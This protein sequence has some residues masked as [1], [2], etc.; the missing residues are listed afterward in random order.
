M[1]Q[2]KADVLKLFTSGG[3]FHASNV[4]MNTLNFSNLVK[5]ILLLFALFSF[6]SE[7]TAAQSSADLAADRARAMNL[8][9][10]NRYI[11]AYPVLEK[12][13]ALLPND[14]DV[15]THYG[16]AAAARSSILRDAKERKAQ[17]K[18]AFDVLT[19]AKQLG[20]ANVMALHILDQLPANGGDEDNFGSENPE[21]E[22]AL[23][24]GE[25]HFGRGDYPKAHDSYAKAFKLNPK[26]YEAVLFLGDTFYAQKKYSE[27]E[28]WFAKAVALDPNREL[29]YR[30]WGDALMS[31]NKVKEATGKFIDA[32]IADP[33]GRYAWENINKLTQK[34]G[35]Q[36]NVATILP[37]GNRAFEELIVNPELLSSQDG[38]KFWLRYQE[39]RN[40]WKREMYKKDFPDKPYRDSLKEG[41]AAI[42][43]MAEAAA[44]AINSGSL[45]NPH[46]SIVNAIEL[47]NKG[48]IEPY[49]LIMM[50]NEGIAEDYVSY[51]T[52]NRDRIRKYLS[53]Y[54]FVF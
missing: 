19:K 34:H 41:A 42:R 15:W 10:E 44:S 3:S 24:E 9:N 29:A 48:L 30:F 6:S 52:S 39:V 45:K 1:V 26:S 32:F 51:R 25:G 16:I 12:V 22:K 8:V 23:R 40:S 5:I 17:R 46:P 31:Q 43:A 38:T 18:R 36:F 4:L 20:T 49:V 28:P 2:Q 54:V 33:Y 11:D 53:E 21:V 27:S 7:P 35:K 14:I 13:A 47:N 50:A 37:P